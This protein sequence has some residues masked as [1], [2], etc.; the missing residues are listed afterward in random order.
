MQNEDQKRL[1]KVIDYCSMFL[2]SARTYN[3]DPK[4]YPILEKN[5]QNLLKTNF[6]DPQ[7]KLEGVGERLYFFD[8]KWNN[9]AEILFGL[10]GK[11]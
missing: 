7:I 8:C 3:V 11:V 9:Y 1:R 4:L 5:Y 10:L 2:T 6:D